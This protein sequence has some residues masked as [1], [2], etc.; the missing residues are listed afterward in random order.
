MEHAMRYDS[1]VGKLTVCAG[2]DGITALVLAGQKYEDCHLAAAG[3]DDPAGDAL[4]VVRQWLDAYFSGEKP[5]HARLP[6][7]PRGTAFQKRVWKELLEIPC[8][9]TS[10]YAALAEKLGSSPRAVGQAVGRNPVSILIPCHRVVGRD[11]S[12]TGYA[13]GLDAKRHLLTLEGVSLD[14]SG[15]RLACGENHE[16]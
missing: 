7:A 6:L 8:G 3:Q 5:D 12:L 9:R 13:G 2:K 11:G 16:K 10:T 4:V 15:D 14:R 1:P